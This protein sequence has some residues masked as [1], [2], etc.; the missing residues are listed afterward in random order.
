METTN[1]RADELDQQVSIKIGGFLFQLFF[2]MPDQI[3]D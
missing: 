2:S 3:I 1:K